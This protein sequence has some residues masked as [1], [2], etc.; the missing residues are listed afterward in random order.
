MPDAT[1]VDLNPGHP[2]VM[3]A[4]AQNLPFDDGTFSTVHAVNPYGFNPVNAETARVMERGGTLIVSAARANKFRKASDEAIQEA[5]FELVDRGTGI[6]PEHM[7][8]TM[9]RADGGAIDPIQ[10]PYEWR[11]Y[12]RL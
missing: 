1:N 7:F 6:H 12:R 10:T 9:R 8:G 5:G 4:D 11:V 2:D 3:Q